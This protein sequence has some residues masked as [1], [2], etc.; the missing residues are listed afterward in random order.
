MKAL[1]FAFGSLALVGCGSMRPVG[2]LSKETPVI[3]QS[4]PL[5]TDAASRPPSLK[6]TP[7]TLI[8]AETDVDPNR[9]E[10]A[11][12]KLTTELTIDSKASAS[13]PV[14]VET[15]RYQNGVKQP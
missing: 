3:Q 13:V 6:P 1:V 2:V 8:V 4:Q 14:T 15:S 11:A 9:P 5:P 7:P 12:G 10:I